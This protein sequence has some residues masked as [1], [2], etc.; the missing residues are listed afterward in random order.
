MGRFIASTESLNENQDDQTG[1]LGMSKPPAF[2]LYAD[3]FIAGTM[4]M[5]Q[6]EVGAY[7]RL[8]CHQWS[9]G[10]IDSDPERLRRMAGGKVSDVVLEKFVEDGPGKICNP[11]LKLLQDGQLAYRKK[12][13]DLANL[14]WLKEAEHAKALPTHIP[15]ACSPIS[16]L[17]S[18]KKKTQSAGSPA[19]EVDPLSIPTELHSPEFTAAW[20]RWMTFR[21]G[22][23]KKPKNWALLFGEQLTWLK[24]FGA[25]QGAAILQASIRNGWQGLFEPKIDPRA[26]PGA[27]QPGVNHVLINAETWEKQEEHREK[28]KAERERTARMSAEIDRKMRELEEQ[29]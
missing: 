17:Q 10:S 16:N 8:L 14:R 7:I 28:V 27:A 18:P 5:T 12:Q 20:Q 24:Q 2:Q 23:G 6:A 1:V 19:V 3:D 11:R 15:N 29:P 21:R 13:S 9:K 25:A 4:G 22:L 26:K